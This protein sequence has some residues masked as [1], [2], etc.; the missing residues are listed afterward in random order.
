MRILYLVLAGVIAI[1]CF[2]SL[3]W[4]AC[5]GDTNCDGDV[6]GLDIANMASSFGDTNCTGPPCGGVPSGYSILGDTPTE[7]AGYTR[8]GTINI[9]GSSWAPSEPLIE[10]MYGHCAV[11][12]NGY[13]FVIG[14][15][16]A[17][18]TSGRAT[19]K[20]WAY[21]LSRNEWRNI[22]NMPTRREAPACAVAGGKIYV[23]GGNDLGTILDVNEAYDP[24][25]DSWETVNEMPIGRTGV[26]GASVNGKIYVIGGTDDPSGGPNASVE[27]YD[28]LTDTWE[29]KA[30][31]PSGRAYFAAAVAR[32]SIFAIGG[33]GSSTVNEEYDTVAN[34][35]TIR[36]PIPT[37]RSRLA[38]VNK[39]GIIHVFG[40]VGGG[41]TFLDTHEVYFIGGNRWE[42]KDSLPTERRYLAAVEISGS[43]LVI[44]G[45]NSAGPVTAVEKLIGDELLYIFRKD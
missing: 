27:V 44:G 24:D 32:D 29:S 41:F 4:S 25:S 39:N 26:A 5:E 10:A 36:T 40:G 15:I 1:F 42:Q 45:E 3:S 38:A 20:V 13:L 19:S 14:G 7:P 16:E 17:N 18:H 8:A 37:G 2:T 11:I 6:D 28:P 31:M 34:S 9:G 33:E 22:V 23:I 43:I 12:L 30:P 21:D 35:W